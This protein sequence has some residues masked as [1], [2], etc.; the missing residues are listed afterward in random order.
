MAMRRSIEGRR[1]IMPYETICGLGRLDLSDIPGRLAERPS[2]DETDCHW[3]GTRCAGE[4]IVSLTEKEY[5]ICSICWGRSPTYL[6][7]REDGIT[8][9]E[10][11]E[12]LASKPREAAASY[13][14]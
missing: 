10:A 8:H 11:L 2:Y 13:S 9:E 1:Q 14:L 5:I 4:Y 12:W 3:C 7:M 6:E